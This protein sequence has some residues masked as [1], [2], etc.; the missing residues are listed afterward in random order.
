LKHA[1]LTCYRFQDDWVGTHINQT[2]FIHYTGTFLAWHRWFIWHYEQALR[3]ECGY[4]GYQPYWNWGLTAITGLKNSPMLDGSDFSMSGD[5]EYVEREGDI[6]LGGNGLPE[7]HLPLG[8]GG[9]CVTSGPFANMTVNLGPFA[10]GEP[11]GVTVQNG[12]GLGYNPRCLKRDL[13]D[14]VNRR[15]ANAS[16]ILKLIMGTHNVYD[17]QM[18]MQGVPGSGDIGVHGG[19]KSTA[20]A[21]RFPITNSFNQV[22]TPW[23]AIPVAMSSPLPATLSSICTTQ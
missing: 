21:L 4:K 12:N 1:T 17:F 2:N 15:F 22:T 20:F 7:I 6:I 5:G 11:N 16:S 19:G 3:N 13:T 9:G 8:T 14:E 18:R 23:A 10:L